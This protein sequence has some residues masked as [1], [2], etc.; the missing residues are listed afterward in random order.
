MERRRFLGAASVSAGL[1]TGETSAL[2]VATRQPARKPPLRLGTVT[3]NLGRSWDLET[4]IRNCTETG[5]EG[6]ELRSTHAHGVEIDIS[7]EKRRE[8]MMRF[9]DSPV[10]L[11]GLGS[12][13][14]YHSP[15][16]EVLRRNIEETKAFV[17]L[18]HDV[19]APGVKVRPNGLPEGVPEEK[20]L[21]QIGLALRECGAFGNGWGV[22][23]RMEV[24]GRETGRI[25]RIRKM[26]DLRGSRQRPDLLELQQD[27]PPGR[28]SGDQLQPDQGPDRP[29]PHEGP[30]HRGVPLAALVPSAPGDGIPGLLPGRDPREHRSD[31]GHAI[32]PNPVSSLPGSGLRR[33]WIRGFLVLRT[34]RIR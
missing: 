22:Q 18:A 28:G 6:V 4:L 17:R 26:L 3:Y 25:P 34:S 13:C 14:E 21:E 5:F 23:I 10:R 11:V 27:G 12:A 20:T 30:L 15:D 31:P 33:R 9:Q 8:V 1:R 2:P 7:P 32:L 29:G 16:P 24:H 19:G